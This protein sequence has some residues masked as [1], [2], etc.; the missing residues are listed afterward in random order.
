MPPSPYA[1]AKP[2]VRQTLDLF[3][4]K[5]VSA[6]PG[7]LG[8]GHAGHFEDDRIFWARDRFDELGVSLRDA[9]VLELGPLEGGHSSMLSRL[10]ARAVTAIEANGEAFLRCL[11]AKELL[12]M[13]RVNFLY[14]DAV[15]YLRGE[16]P[17]YDIGIACGFLYH[18]VDPVELIEL[19]CKKTS[20]VFLWTV[21]WDPEFN[22]R[23]P[24][25]AA[26]NG[27]A[28]KAVRSGFRHTLHRQDYGPVADYAKFLG[29]PASY[30][31]WME[32]RDI[33]AAFAHF[34]FGQMRYE[35]EQNLNGSALRLVAR[36]G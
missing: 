9:T 6:F 16:T 32:L 29:G 20:A 13:E 18:M 25:K 23:N 33:L 2:S 30:S 28:T 4:G 1:S 36:R 3:A 17:S 31:E 7:G 35:L 22:A 10:G 14:G 19:L 21:Y 11:V 12:G 26:A 5:W 8:G 34:G 15:D 27:P 24:T